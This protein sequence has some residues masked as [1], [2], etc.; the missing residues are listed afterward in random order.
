MYRLSSTAGPVEGVLGAEMRRERRFKAPI[1]SGEL[2]GGGSRTRPRQS[3]TS[4]R[5]TL[6]LRHPQV[7]LTVVRLHGLA[8]RVAIVSR[9]PLTFV[10]VRDISV[11]LSVGG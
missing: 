5:S 4:G 11:V 8:T 10:A 6:R 2:V 9:Q 3:C 7:L 1:S